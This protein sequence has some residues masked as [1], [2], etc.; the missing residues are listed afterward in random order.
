MFSIP[1]ANDI[2]SFANVQDQLVSLITALNTWAQQQHNN[3]GSHS[4]VTASSMALG[5]NP[6]GVVTS[7][8]VDSSLFTCSS[9]GGVWAVDPANV[10]LYGYAACN[11]LMW[12]NFTVVT[13][14]ITGAAPTNLFINTPQF[15]I[16]VAYV[17]SNNTASFFIGG[18][19]QWIDEQHSTNNSG[20]VAIQNTAVS[21]GLPPSPHLVL[22]AAPS[23]TGTS[24]PISNNLAVRGFCVF[25]ITPGNTAQ[26]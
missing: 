7:L 13:S 9:G 11:Q 17:D 8:P 2:K 21:H 1:S 22:Q 15:N 4:H 10:R 20:I 26:F 12:V 18:M 19:C 3:D 23:F 6:V 16:P 5:G 25:P 14:T 24:F